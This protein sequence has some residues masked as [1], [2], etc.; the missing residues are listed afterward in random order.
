[1]F[2]NSAAHLMKQLLLSTLALLLATIAVAQPNIGQP[3]TEDSSKTVIIDN[4]DRLKGE[5]VNGE[6]IR[7]FVGNVQLHQGN[8][9]MSCD[10]AVMDLNSNIRAFGDVLI[11][12]SDTV[13][14]FADSLQYNSVSRTANLLGDVVLTDSKAEL[15]TNKLDYDF[16]TKVAK[17][18]TS[19]I[20][21]NRDTRLYSK[22]GYYYVDKKEIYFKDSVTVVDPDYSLVS[23]TLKIDTETNITHFL[24]PTNIINKD[25][26]IYCE[27]GFYDTEKNY[28]EFEKN[29]KFQSI[30]GQR[31]AVGDKIIYNGKTDETSLIG[32][33]FFQDSTR[34]VTADE[35]VYNNETEAYSTVGA[36]EIKNGT[37]TITSEGKSAYDGVRQVAIFTKRVRI[38]DP[39]TF[40]EADSLEY[41]QT[42]H[43]AQAFGN[44]FFE[45]TSEHI[46]IVCEQADY[47]DSTE[48]FLAI[49]RPLMTTLIE[50]DTLYLAADT[51]K[52]YY[53]DPTD[54]TTRMII[55]DVDVRVYKSDLQAVCDSLMYSDADSLFQFFKDP[56]IWS[57]TSQFSSDTVRIVLANE[58]IDKIYLFNNAFIINSPDEVFFN[59]I[60]GRN[61]EADFIEDQLRTINVEG[62][63]ESVYYIQDDGKA[64]LGVNKTICSEMFIFFGNNEIEKIKFITQPKA[65]MFPMKQANH[66]KLRL[67]G[68]RWDMDRRPRGVWDLR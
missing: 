33:A 56:I 51:L 20:I 64:Y 19:A 62:S 13:N 5:K 30:D 63:G 6:E 18:N 9:I 53:E 47:N 58:T 24:G 11:Q 3:T 65:T 1:M 10:S 61:V 29:A 66:V 12:Q 2:K 50:N 43:F 16:N 39:P 54:T 41:S 40:L 14:I 4:A 34:T 46:S 7:I 60:K 42:T 26:Q 57:D 28:A 35:I 17:Y 27:Q 52:S 23:D 36:T 37:Q 55:A 15:F 38:S 67:A 48:Y 31:K 21:K 59:Q 32:N 22:V 44:V 68:F 25:N 45:D 8:I 49:G